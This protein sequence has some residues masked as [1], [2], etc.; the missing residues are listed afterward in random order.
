MK[1]SKSK[2]KGENKV[3]VQMRRVATNSPPMPKDLFDKL[4][5]AVIQDEGNERMLEWSLNEDH[6]LDLYVE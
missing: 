3:T 6:S 5:S 4:V 1:R 2:R